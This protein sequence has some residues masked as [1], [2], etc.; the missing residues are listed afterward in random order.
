MVVGSVSMC[1]SY[2][3]DKRTQGFCLLEGTQRFTSKGFVQ[4]Y[5][6][7]DQGDCA[8]K[9]AM[10]C[11]EFTNSSSRR[12]KAGEGHWRRAGAADVGDVSLEMMIFICMCV[13]LGSIFSTR[14]HSVDFKC[15]PY[16]LACWC[17]WRNKASGTNRMHTG[18]NL[19]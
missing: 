5:N 17:R 16:V 11:Y 15:Q 7:A 2:A 4:A 8:A 6:A 10:E 9:N 14:A 13:I 1:A 18:Q 12:M 3:V 19:D